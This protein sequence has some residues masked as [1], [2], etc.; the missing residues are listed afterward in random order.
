LVDGRLALLRR[1][2][3][4]VGAVGRLELLPERLRCGGLAAAPSQQN[5]R[6]RD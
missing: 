4:P 6:G 2:L 3:A 1:R 5:S